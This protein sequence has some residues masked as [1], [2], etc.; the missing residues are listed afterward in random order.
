MDEPAMAPKVKKGKMSRKQNQKPIANKHEI[1]DDGFS[2]AGESDEDRQFGVNLGDFHESNVEEDDYNDDS[3][4]SDDDN[5]DDI[6]EALEGED[7]G[8]QSR[9]RKHSEAE[10]G[11]DVS[12]SKKNKKN[13]SSADLKKPPTA[14]E[15]ARLRE[16]ENLFHSNIFRLQIEEMLK[17]TSIKQ[18]RLASF[19][20]WFTSLK[21]SLTTMTKGEKHEIMDQKWLKDLGVKIPIAQT[22]YPL[23]GVF[24]FFPPKSV[25]VTG[26]YSIGCSLGPN[27]KVDIA[28][29]MPP[30]CFQGSDNLNQRYLRKRALYLCQIV[31]HLKTAGLISTEEDLGPHFEL[32]RAFNPL[33]PVAVV[34]PVG[35]LKKHTQV[36]LHVTASEEAFKMTKFGP[37]KNSIRSNWYFNEEKTDENNSATPLQNATIVSDLVAKRNEDFKLKLLQDSKNAKD[38]IILLKVWLKQREL[39]QGLSAFGSHLMTML[40]VY[41]LHSRKISSHMSSYQVARTV[42]NFLK[43]CDWTV[44]GRGLSLCDKPPIGAPG[45]SEFHDHYPV[46]FVDVTGY[47]NLAAHMDVASFKRIQNESTLAIHYLDNTSV[48]SFQV[49]FMKPVPFYQHFDHILC[50]YDMKSLQQM[51]DKKSSKDSKLDKSQHSLRLSA[52]LLFEVLQRGLGKRVAEWGI[53]APEK[54]SWK[55]KKSPP[56]PSGPLLLGMKLDTEHAYSILDKGPPADLPEAHEFRKFWGEKSELRRFQDGSISEAVVWLPGK[57]V[58]LSERRVVNKVITEYLLE[59]KLGLNTSNCLAY[60]ADQLEEVLTLSHVKPPFAYGSGEEAALGVL[61][62]LDRLSVEL[63]GLPDLPLDI[64]GVQGSS[65]VCRFADVFPPLSS[66]EYVGQKVTNPDQHCLL[67]GSGLK[68]SEAPV[69]ISPVEVVLQLSLS[70]KWPDDAQAV[71]RVRAAFN[72]KIANSLRKECGLTTQAFPNYVDIIKEG[73][74]F[75]LRVA[76]QREPALLR[77]LVLPDGM[78]TTVDCKE[79]QSLEKETI[80]APKLTSYLHGLHQQQ[81]AFGPATCLA[82]R[83][84][85][86]QM[87][88]WAHF[89]EE[90]VELLMAYIF[91]SPE[92]FP[93]PAQ[94]QA[95]FM[96]FLHLLSTTNWHLEPIILNF[97]NKLSKT[98][99]SEIEKKF[100]SERV[101]LPTLF[102]ATP[103]EHEYSVWTKAAPSLLILARV[104][105]LAAESLKV[106]QGWYLAGMLFESNVWKQIF[107]PSLDSYDLIIHLNSCANPRRFQCIDSK[108]DGFVQ[109]LPVYQKTTKEKIPVVGFDPVQCY[110][111]ELEAAYSEYALFFHDIYGGS[112]IGVVWKPSALEPKEF[113]VAHLF[114]RKLQGK[115]SN[116]SL[117]LNQ[118]ALIEDFYILGQG[119][120]KFIDSK[121]K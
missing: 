40:V 118:E 115:N 110:L 44:H 4:E 114:G 7:G 59:N 108:V 89:P 97:N 2:S 80:H 87:I 32:P 76:Y 62:A 82:K 101:Q 54:L 25:F 55:I 96:R 79:A 95:A 72:I 98:T 103:S 33:L 17:E 49:L 78:M 45:L 121:N 112:V 3:G 74:V 111:Q 50:F 91:V 65:A 11:S 68:Y 100:S 116:Q 10:N 69:W 120:V 52:D 14:Q 94:P 13:K 43:E 22:P 119:L 16:T 37:S 8:D 93:A 63:R 30:E 51:N 21:D 70:G 47:Y 48:N 107:R 29:E 102:I 66:L 39:D 38:G 56:V 77:Q 1:N 60:L 88:R 31:A 105:I 20:E 83:W 35:S 73:Y 61:A 42:W 23:K 5:G 12:S 92:P 117:V 46:V 67:L 9:K 75:R 6:E 113:K 58:S 99:V 71:R 57:D 15:V 53:H 27:L 90:A 28:I 64:S 104:A 19:S 86:A 18:K 24:Q 84:L 34:V 41:L 26:S 85:S 106:L 81:P 36:F 109:N